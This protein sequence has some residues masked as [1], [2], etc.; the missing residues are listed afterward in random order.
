M[1]VCL[2]IKNTTMS[3][4]EDLLLAF[5]DRL[6]SDESLRNRMCEAIRTNLEN[7]IRYYAR[8]VVKEYR[9]VILAQHN[10]FSNMCALGYQPRTIILELKQRSSGRS[11]FINVDLQ[12]N[13]VTLLPAFKYYEFMKYPELDKIQKFG[14][15]E[16][17]PDLDGLKHSIGYPGQGTAS[18]VRGGR[19]APSVGDFPEHGN[20]E[21][22]TSN[23]QA[24][25]AATAFYELQNMNPE[26]TSHDDRGKLRTNSFRSCD[27]W[28]RPRT[29]PVNGYNQEAIKDAESEYDMIIKE[30]AAQWSMC[31]AAIVR[32]NEQSGTCTVDSVIEA[33]NYFIES[34]VGSA[35]LGVKREVTRLLTTYLQAP[36]YFQDKYLNF[37]LTGGAG[38]GKTTVANALGRLL[39][40][41]GI[42]VRPN[43]TTHSRSTL[44][45]A[46]IGETADKTRRQLLN[47]LEGVMFIDE[48]YAITQSSSGGGG[49]GGPTYDPY[50][51]ECINEF[52]NFMDKTKGRICIIVA[53]YADEMRTYWFG[54]NEGMER[55][56]SGIWQLP[57]YTA[58]DLFDISTYFYRQEFKRT[59]FLLP[60]ETAGTTRTICD[61][62]EDQDH[63]LNLFVRCT[64]IVC[65][66]TNGK[67]MARLRNQAGDVENIVRF[68]TTEFIDRIRE[69][70]GGTYLEGTLLDNA[71]VAR[72]FEDRFVVSTNGDDTSARGVVASWEGGFAVVRN[73]AS[74]ASSIRVPQI[75]TEEVGQILENAR[76][77]MRGQPR[78][79]QLLRRSARQAGVGAGSVRMTAEEEAAGRLSR[80][81]SMAT[82][83]TSAPP[84]QPHRSVTD[85]AGR[86]AQQ[87]IYTREKFMTVLQRTLAGTA[88]KQWVEIQ[89][90][91]RFV[92]ST[93]EFHTFEC[94][95]GT[96]AKDVF[97]CVT[98]E[99]TIVPKSFMKVLL[100][101]GSENYGLCILGKTFEN[102]GR[103]RVEHTRPDTQTSKNG[104]YPIVTFEIFD[105]VF[106]D[107]EFETIEADYHGHIILLRTV[108]L[109]MFVQVFFPFYANW[110]DFGEELLRNSVVK[111]LWY[112][113]NADMTTMATDPVVSGFKRDSLKPRK[114]ELYHLNRI[115]ISMRDNAIRCLQILEQQE[116]RE[117]F[118]IC[119]RSVGISNPKEFTNFVIKF[120]TFASPELTTR[121]TA[122]G[123]QRVMRHHRLRAAIHKLKQDPTNRALRNDVIQLVHHNAHFD[124]H[125]LTIAM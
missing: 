66:K 121:T 118:E 122:F 43:M 19:S 2:F 1:Y 51:V 101:T 88:A 17:V 95:P 42:L 124:K 40:A 78:E 49:G 76:Q 120:L 32:L 46:Y 114:Y 15:T 23:P 31:T 16:S 113:Y 30:A 29:R 84:L 26:L 73:S 72:V 3:G 55:R 96:N 48:A 87:P 98:D 111:M 38:T 45:G 74:T 71:F 39:S 47:N 85:V 37:A 106:T 99:G 5:R 27:A 69:V 107:P 123:R 10:K 83:T 65:G 119:A 61:I 22:V 24:L 28:S 54:P 34:V 41:V 117:T 86:E 93:T 110:K 20:F 63:L 91:V 80:Q 104:Y 11:V 100:G 103:R 70:S 9:E 125:G 8:S 105:T 36:T 12:Y 77:G 89:A 6:V 64:D 94:P 109:E 102:T 56:M 79:M 25:S 108:C 115:F 62:V 14:R 60:H 92:V 33:L 52:I 82:S 53:G 97:S 21:I 75:K 35:R 4:G 58:Q 7:K 59:P 116:H 81:A 13:M 18:Q 50:G 67:T 57:N 44:V 90:D 112:I 68:L